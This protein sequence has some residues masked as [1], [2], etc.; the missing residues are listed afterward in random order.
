MARFAPVWVASAVLYLFPYLLMGMLSALFGPSSLHVTNF[1][2]EIMGFYGLAAVLLV[3]QRKIFWFLAIVI[4]YIVAALEFY[5]SANLANISM[6]FDYQFTLACSSIIVSA[7]IFYFFRFPYLDG[8]DTGL[9]GIAHRYDSDLPAEI[10]ARLSG[11]V[12]NVSMSGVLFRSTIDVDEFKIGDKVK[13]SV[14]GLNLK[15]V[16]VE[17]RGFDSEYMRL[18]FSWLGFR[19]FRQLQ[20]RLIQLS[21]KS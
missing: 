5:H 9:F 16:P 1:D 10:L 15:E 12:I 14:P 13:L 20:K 3:V 8:R 19:D 18:K 6:P 2:W 11:R 21:S 4:L 17:I 7:Y